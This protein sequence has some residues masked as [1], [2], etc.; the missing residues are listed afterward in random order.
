MGKSMS[1]KYIKNNKEMPPESSLRQNKRKLRNEL[2]LEKITIKQY[3]AVC[4]NARRW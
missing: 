2:S 3:R 4:K 1:G